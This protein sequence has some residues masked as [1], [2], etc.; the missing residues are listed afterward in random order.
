MHSAYLPSI[1]PL[2]ST[3]FAVVLMAQGDNVDK[4][5]ARLKTSETGQ[6]SRYLQGG[7]EKWTIFKT[8]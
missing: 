3:T 5:D 1:Y 7:P 8:A 6:H 4:K 2:H